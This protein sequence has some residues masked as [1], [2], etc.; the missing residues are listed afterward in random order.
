[1]DIFAKLNEII[2]FELDWYDI[3]NEEIQHLLK[4]IS[5]DDKNQ[6]RIKWHKLTFSFLTPPIPISI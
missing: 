4:F 3:S 5:G 2:D 1:M 6:V